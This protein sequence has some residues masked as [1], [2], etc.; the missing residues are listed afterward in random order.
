MFEKRRDVH[1]IAL[2]LV[3][4]VVSALAVLAFESCCIAAGDTP[5]PRSAA[6][7]LKSIRTRNGFAV[8]LVAAEPLVMDPISLD[9][10]PD[11]KL[12]VVEMADYPL[13]LDGNGKPGGR[14]RILEDTDGDG[15][16]D[17]ST[18]FLEDLAYPSAVMVW[19]K[20]VLVSAAPD[21]FYAEDR[22]GDGRADERQV[23]YRGFKPGN[24][25]HR[26]NGFC[27]GL[28]NWV[29]LANGDSDGVVT[30]IRTGQTVNIGGRDLRIRPDAG[31][32]DPQTGRSQYGRSRDD[33]GNWFGSS[34]SQPIMHFV[35]AD[36]RLRRNPH[37]TAPPSRIT[38]ASSQ[39]TV[40]FPIGR[41]ISHWEGY[42]PPGPGEPHRFASACSTS[43][44]RDDLF[45]AE[46]SGNT[47]T[48]EPAHNMVHR[49]VL[50]PSGLTF[51]SQRAAGAEKSEFLASTD[52]WFRPTSIRTGP[53]GALWVVDMY[54]Q[55]IEHPA[56]IDDRLKETLNLRAGH[57]RGRIY[58][59]YPADKRPRPPAR[60]G[61][62]DTPSLVAAL[63]VANGWQRAR[64]HQMLIWRG[65]LTAVALLAEMLSNSQHPRTRIHALCALDGLESL[66]PN[67]LTAALSDPHPAVRRHAVRLVETL[68]PVPEETATVLLQ[69]AD[70]ND[71]HVRLECAY[72]LGQWDDARAGRA[73]GRMAVRHANDPYIFAAVM[74]SVNSRNLEHVLSE[75]FLVEDGGKPSGGLIRQLLSVAAALGDDTV[76][77]R[78]LGIISTP[79]GDEYGAWQLSAL[80]EVL[81]ALDRRHISAAKPLSRAAPKLQSTL[82]NVA[83]MFESARRLAA[84]NRAD[85]TR[86][87]LAV[88]LLGRGP[89]DRQEDIVALSQLLVPRSPLEL[90][91][92]VVE[93]LG[94]LN[95]DR[96]SQVL[97]AG[98]KHHGPR[99]RPDI[100]EVLMSRQTGRSE[101]LTFIEQGHIRAA[102]INASLRRWLLTDENEAIKRRAEQL[103]GPH[104]V[105]TPRAQVV[106]ELQSVLSL[107]GNRSRGE[108]IFNNKCASCHRI[109]D[110]GHAV[111]PDL[112]AMINRS[113]KTL[114]AAILDPNRAVEAKFR[115]YSALTTSGRQFTGLLRDETGQ[116]ITLLGLEGKQQTILRTELDS[117]TNIGQSFMPEGMEKDLTHRDLADVVGYLTSLGT[118]AKQF[119][120]NHP[121]QISAGDDGCYLLTA[122]SA[123]IFGNT[124][125]FRQQDRS[126]GSWK[127]VGDRAVWT[128]N[129][130]E[131][132]MYAVL[133]DYAMA[134]SSRDNRYALDTDSASLTGELDSTGDAL[135]YAQV[136]LGQLHLPCGNSSITMRSAPG[137]PALRVG[138]RNIWLV[139][140]SVA[141]ARVR[142]RRPDGNAP[143]LVQPDSDGGFQLPVTACEIRGDKTIFDQRQKSLAFWPDEDGR[144]TWTL[145]VPKAGRFFVFAEYAC[146][147][148]SLGSSFTL[149]SGGS[150]RSGRILGTGSWI[151]YRQRLVGMLDLEAGV[152]RLSFHCAGEAD[153]CLIDLR[154]IW[155]VPEIPD[156]LSEE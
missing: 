109:D 18:L 128:L 118:S 146:G 85:P 16:Y 92:A 66:T 112:L 57:D 36:H 8:E 148:S 38:I 71:P 83:R 59:V 130:V 52:S 27:W 125:A 56:L 114:L 1:R 108:S 156:G 138:L 135:P 151:N 86:R 143:R 98:W 2:V 21:V 61:Q 4:T 122:E 142:Q 5:P 133:M 145:D 115:T 53:D 73:L 29:H 20:G 101:L 91:R 9:W 41:V 113:P 64:V 33:W 110:L 78:V 81:D 31:P 94:K 13:G 26:V 147:R 32:L 34:N 62:L 42:R 134:Q 84:D 120:G 60:L 88:K 24:P 46:F 123:Y 65:D 68:Q 69:R 49:R 75:V 103:F 129:V 39:N 152:R 10:G 63:D 136:L 35:L 70:D 76:L 144:T 82:E 72:V 43:F 90:Q 3:P 155:L 104:S 153:T 6:A 97:V 54:R 48:C 107:Q 95:D 12:W 19:R 28:D 116:S 131:S 58:R 124:L 7:S 126:L 40:I 80:S 121:Q 141:D 105:H 50:Q 127:D 154:K 45:G 150:R 137:R 79:S 77:I 74:S 51:T 47:F 89:S 93:S 23:L 96:V 99:L 102:D 100:L 111:G 14:V 139:P 140:M 55:V 132:G 117:L 44:Y 30:S 15:K 106:A 67:V 87:Q 22:D 17:K 11:G 37:M 119:V 149:S 25:Q